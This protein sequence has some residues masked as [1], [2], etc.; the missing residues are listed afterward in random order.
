MKDQASALS[1]RVRPRVILRHYGQLCL[2]TSILIAIPS[3]V[4]LANGEFSIALRYLIVAVPLLIL[5]LLLARVHAGTRIRTNEAMVVAV[6]AFVVTPLLMAYPLMSAD[7]GATDALFEAVS[8]ITTT[9]LTTLPTIN[10][11]PDSFLF[12]RA[13]MQWYGGLGIVALSLA[14]VF[15]PGIVAKRLAV[16]E[17]SDDDLIG[18]MKEHA[19]VI[20]AVYALLTIVV[21]G[22]LA[23]TGTT[24]FN[25]VLYALA[26]VST[27]GFAPATRSLA[28]LP[29]H[30]APILVTLGCLA[31]ANSFILYRRAYRSGPRALLMDGQFLV[32]LASAGAVSLGLVLTMHF[33]QAMPWGPSLWNGSLLGLSAQTTSGFSTMNI[34]Q[35]HPFAKAIVILSMLVGGDTGSTSGGIKIIRMVVF[36]RILQLTLARC[37][38]TR[39]AVV[40]PRVGQHRLENS[41]IQGALLLIVTLVAVAFLS[42]LAF[43]LGGYDPLDALF[44]VVSALGTV[45]LSTGVAGPGL[46]PWLKGVLCLDMLMGR[47]EII[48]VLV[49]LRPQTWLGQQGDSQ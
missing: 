45:G 17:S 13:W 9:G 47:L 12:A 15:Q 20:L 8:G 28:A 33:L 42:W 40:V 37:A 14:L 30:A 1:Y 5:G 31:G 27:G 23:I 49:F 7:I 36:L 46:S 21:I 26:A 41:D 4:C 18:N 32:L 44:D 34:G 10:G 19:R 6:L 43:L 11:R 22:S 2:V 25:C 16:T 38:M 39:H 24:A 48:P 29:G 3:I 35:L